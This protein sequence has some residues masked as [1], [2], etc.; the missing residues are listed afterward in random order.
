MEHTGRCCEVCGK[1]LHEGLR[2]TE[3][4]RQHLHDNR[5]AV[6]EVGGVKTLRVGA[7]TERGPQPISAGKRARRSVIVFGSHVAATLP[8]NDVG[9]RAPTERDRRRPAWNRAMEPGEW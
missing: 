9:V 2:R 6:L 7:R 8:L 5:R 3:P 4:R 1:A